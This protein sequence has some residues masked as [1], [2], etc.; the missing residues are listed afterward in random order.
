MESRKRQV[1]QTQN[2]QV[3]SHPNDR[4]SRVVV[5]DTKQVQKAMQLLS[6]KSGVTSRGTCLEADARDRQDHTPTATKKGWHFL[7]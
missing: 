1:E 3:F 7:P 6:M 4:E 5:V 2:V